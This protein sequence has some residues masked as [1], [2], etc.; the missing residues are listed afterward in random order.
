MRSSFILLA[1]LL[2]VG[3][4]WAG[5]LTVIQAYAPRSLTPT[6]S[7]AAVYFTIS[8]TGEADKIVAISTPAAKSAMIHESRIVD[9]IATMNMLNSIDVPADSTIAMSQGGLHVMLTGLIA[10]LVEGESLNLDVTFEKAGVLKVE[11]PVTGLKG[12]TAGNTP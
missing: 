11:V 7:S 1:F 6:T 10:P 2:L 8:N 12:P 3:K 9:D 5:E 4:G